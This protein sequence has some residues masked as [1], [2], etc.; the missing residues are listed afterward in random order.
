[1]SK[2]DK[3][4]TKNKQLKQKI[5]A[6]LTTLTTHTDK[7]KQKTN[8]VLDVPSMSS[9]V[10]NSVKE[11]I[12]TLIDDKIIKGGYRVVETLTQRNNID[13][14][15]RKR[16]MVVIVVGED[17]SF[18]EYI[19]KGE[20]LCSNDSWEVYTVDTSVSED[21]VTLNSDYSELGQ[22]ILETQEELNKVLTQILLAL[23]TQIS[24][25]DIPTKTSD[26]TNDGEDGIHP[27]ITSEDI[28][29][30]VEQVNADWNATSGKAEILNKPTIPAPVDIS[31][32]LDKP[33]APDNVPTKVILGD[34]TT[35][36]LSEITTDISG[37]EDKSNKQN[38]LAVDGTGIKYPTVDAVNN[39]L[40]DKIHNPEGGVAGNIL[41][42]DAVDGAKWSNRLT[43]AETEIDDLSIHQIVINTS[44]SIT[45]NT[46]G[47][48]TGKGQHG[49]NVKISNGVNAINIT[50]ETASNADFVASYTKL[51]SGAIT[52][53]AGSGA[54]L[55]QVDGTA[56]LNGVVGSTACLTRNGNTY[57]LQISNR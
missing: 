29:A 55:V 43:T 48:V 21:E 33:L 16:G 27:F 8:T 34:G 39:G 13:C 19:L 50:C 25:L 17:L 6:N 18:I 22:D 56:I 28:P 57:Y 44:V 32:K 2:L 11:Y 14:C 23:Q 26:L 15:Y 46:V 41:E 51:G 12:P 9:K 53:V 24:N 38:S 37:K 20:D 52:F 30:P 3:I 5:N 49:R 10:I 1:M 7:I 4:T 40:N 42:Y 45:T 31:G 47:S 35:K 54:T 36:N